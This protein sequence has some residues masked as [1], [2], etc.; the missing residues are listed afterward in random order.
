MRYMIMPTQDALN[1][2]V[3]VLL[4]SIKGCDVIFFIDL[5]FNDKVISL[6]RELYSLPQVSLALDFYNDG[7]L[8]LNRAMEKQ[9]FKIRI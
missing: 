4:H 7:V 8:F 2:N 6:W 9:Y 5:R 1:K 3:E